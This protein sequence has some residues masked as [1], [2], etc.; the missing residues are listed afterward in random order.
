MTPNGAYVYADNSASST[1][2]GFTLSKNGI[3]NPIG[4]TI[5]ATLPEGSTNLEASVSA[6][7]KFLYTLNAGLGTIGVFAVDR[8]GHL[9]EI[10]VDEHSGLT[11]A[12]GN[13]GLAAF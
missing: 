7:G 4:S 11:P 2:A 9:T 13:E 6:D 10:Q 3:L 12:A 1:I 8:D 5:L